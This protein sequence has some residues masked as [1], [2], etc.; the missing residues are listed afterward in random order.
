MTLRLLTL[1]VVFTVA[2]V[3]FWRMW[4]DITDT[5][6]TVRFLDEHGFDTITLPRGMTAADVWAL[7]AEIEALPEVA[8]V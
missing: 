2:T 5:R 8:H 6:E 1:A 7:L 4:D 3:T